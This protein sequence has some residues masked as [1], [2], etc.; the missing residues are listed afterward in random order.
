MSINNAKDIE[1]VKS[2][3]NVD[4]IWIEEAHEVIEDAYEELKRRLRG[5]KGG[6][7]Q[8]ICSFNP[9]GITS[10]LYDRFFIRNV[11]NITKIKTNDKIVDRPRNSIIVRQL[12]E[13]FHKGY[14]S[15]LIQMAQGQEKQE[16]Q[17]H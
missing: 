15:A 5:G 8:I 17:W 9:V 10:W 1:K 6:L 12:A 14:R 7:S 4:M 2:V 11:D 3:T 13:H 16:L